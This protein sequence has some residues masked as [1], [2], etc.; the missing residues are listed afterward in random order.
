MMKNLIIYDHTHND[1][2]RHVTLADSALIYTIYNKR[3]LVFELFNGKIF[4][5]GYHETVK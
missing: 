1:G 2:N 5:I 4:P 3:Y